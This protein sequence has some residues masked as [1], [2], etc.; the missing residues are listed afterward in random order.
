VAATP[1]DLVTAAWLCREARDAF[2]DV[3]WTSWIC[4][5][6]VN[7]PLWQRHLVGGAAWVPL[8][9]TYPRLMAS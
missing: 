2:S 4:S 6:S 7:T 1:K 9:Y 5:P 3:L 8:P